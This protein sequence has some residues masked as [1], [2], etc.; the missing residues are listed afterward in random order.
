MA[1]ECTASVVAGAVPPTRP[2]RAREQLV[3][4][5]DGTLGDTFGDSLCT[6]VWVH[7]GKRTYISVNGARAG[8]PAIVVATLTRHGHVPCVFPAFSFRTSSAATSRPSATT[9][10]CTPSAPV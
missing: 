7:D 6:R 5:I 3:A 9:T 4:S 1:E 8:A 10:S 2:E